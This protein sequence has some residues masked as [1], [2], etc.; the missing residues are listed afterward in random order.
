MI[1]RDV[2]PGDLFEVSTDLAHPSIAIRA[3]VLATRIDMRPARDQQDLEEMLDLCTEEI[4]AKLIQDYGLQGEIERRIRLRLERD[5]YRGMVWD[6]SSGE[7]AIRLSEL[8]A[9]LKGQR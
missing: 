1:T 2:K 5:G 4:K 6:P 8:L 7:P 9:V 3:R